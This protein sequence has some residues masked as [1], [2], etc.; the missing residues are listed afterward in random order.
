MGGFFSL[1][2]W[3]T[4]YK[5]ESSECSSSPLLTLCIHY[6]VECS[7]TFFFCYSLF[8]AV[9][10]EVQ[11]IGWIILCSNP[12]SLIRVMVWTSSARYNLVLLFI[13]ASCAHELIFFALL[14][15]GQMGAHTCRLVI[16]SDTFC[17]YPLLSPLEPI[18]HFF[19]SAIFFTFFTD[20]Y[21]TIWLRSQ[22]GCISL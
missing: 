20:V 2:F 11:M 14:K 10:T 13:S 8:F 22:K 6:S 3:N 18:S 12:I 9:C 4:H 7:R 17:L 5:Y 15:L 1:L 16:F 21:Y 19:Y